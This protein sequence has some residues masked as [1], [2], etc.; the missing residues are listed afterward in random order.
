MVSAAASLMG[1]LSIL[2]R[3]HAKSDDDGSILDMTPAR[4]D[5]FWDLNACSVLIVEFA[6]LKP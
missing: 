2:V 4:L 5:A 6:H 1:G 3:N